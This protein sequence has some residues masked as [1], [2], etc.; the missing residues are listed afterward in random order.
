MKSKVGVNILSTFIVFLEKV[1]SKCSQDTS[2]IESGIKDICND[3]KDNSEI[4]EAR[5]KYILE[6]KK[7]YKYLNIIKL[8]NQMNVGSTCSICLSENVTSYFNPCGHTAC[9][10]CIEKNHDKNCP[11]CRSYIQSVHKLYFI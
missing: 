10:N 8:F 7:Y 2:S 5:D 4:K 9:I 6:K 3:I 1:N 11:L